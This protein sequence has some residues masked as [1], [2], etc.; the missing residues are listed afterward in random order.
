[1]NHWFSLNIAAA[2]QAFRRL[3][4]QPIGTLLILLMLGIAITLPLVLHLGV[5]S[6]QQ[7]LGTISSKPQI[8]LYMDLN[9]DNVDV[10]STHKTLSNDKRIEQV[11]MI[12]KESAI[13]EMQR[14]LGDNDI[15]TILENNPLPDAFVVTVRSNDPAAV[16]LLQQEYSHLPMVDSAQVDAKWLKTLHNIQQ[17]ILHILWFLAITLGLAFAL[18][19]YNTIRL[20]TLVCREEIEITK[21]L[22]APAS[23]IRRPFIYL[24]LWQGLLSMLIGIALCAWIRYRFSPQLEGIFT[25]YGVPVKWRF[26]DIQELLVIVL[27]VAFLSI[28]GAWLAVRKHLREYSARV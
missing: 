12:G 24:A 27:I 19:T 1:M 5:Q 8:T 25:Q 22:G 6:T 9:A 3:F 20:Q 23:F 17:F 13:V 11:T 16:E 10:E 7:F 21:L 14:L 15:L 18:I 28:A 26:F 2:Q 4:K